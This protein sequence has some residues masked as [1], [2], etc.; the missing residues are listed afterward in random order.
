[1]EL[2]GSRGSVSAPQAHPVWDGIGDRGVSFPGRGGRW[3][4]NGPERKVTSLLL[5]LVSG[6]RDGGG[7]E[8]FIT[9]G[10]STSIRLQ[11]SPIAD[12]PPP[13]LPGPGKRGEREG[14]RVA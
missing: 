8:E 12:S 1:M 2:H 4:R 5:L 14:R 6:R 7:V 11:L 9:V 10:L 3:Q 13:P